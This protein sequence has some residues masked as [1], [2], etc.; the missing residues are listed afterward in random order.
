MTIGEQSV[1]ALLAAIAGR[2]PT[3]GGGAVAGL[4]LAIGAATGSMVLS[5]SEGKASL[6]GH[7]D[8]HRE[9]KAALEEARAAALRLA[10][11]DAA[12]YGRLSELGKLDAREERRRREM[13]AAVREAIDVPRCCLNAALDVLRLLRH[14]RGATN[15]HLDSDLAI[16]AIL[17]DAAARA[18]ACNVRINLAQLEDAEEAA[19]IE[20]ETARSL[21]EA[22]AL[23]AEVEG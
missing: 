2:T 20:A 23:R 18:A 6:A 21:D 4:T 11:A 16:A 12:A 15:R 7:A 17:A 10:D 1:D 22:G 3:P 9:A 5:Y 13:P 14:L 19:L 8:L